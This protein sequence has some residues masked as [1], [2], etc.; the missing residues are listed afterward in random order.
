MV[1]KGINLVN[2][3]QWGDPT[4]RSSGENPSLGLSRKRKGFNPPLGDMD[5][6][7][8]VGGVMGQGGNGGAVPKDIGGKPQPPPS[9]NLRGFLIPWTKP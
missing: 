4:S 3:L 7:N 9:R 2:A 5:T 1:G 8:M 6:Q